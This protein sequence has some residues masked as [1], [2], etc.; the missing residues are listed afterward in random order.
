MEI[1]PSARK[2]GTVSTTSRKRLL[3][4][5]NI[6]ASVASTTGMAISLTGTLVQMFLIVAVGLGVAS[7]LYRVATAAARRRQTIIDH[8]EFDWI[9]DHKPHN[10]QQV[11]AKRCRVRARIV[12][13]N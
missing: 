12:C 5:G 8:P 2:A 9:D 13:S 3:A 10:W 4:D 11:S 1:G 7:L 6:D